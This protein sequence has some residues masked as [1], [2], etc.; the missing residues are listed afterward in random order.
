MTSINTLQ[1]LGAISAGITGV[2]YLRQY[3]R[4]GVCISNVRM[5]DKTVLI[6]GSNTGIGKETVLDLCRR[7]ARVAMLCRNVE[8]AQEAA[9]EIRKQVKGADIVVYK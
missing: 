5:D 7:G 2:Y 1:T 3:F 6:T 9:T 8:K 4:G